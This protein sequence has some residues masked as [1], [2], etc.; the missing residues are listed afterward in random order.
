MGR[1]NIISFREGVREA[2][3][4]AKQRRVALAL[5]S[6]PAP[7]AWGEGIRPREATVEVKC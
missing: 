7:E 6:D 4:R 2:T 1:F 3:K 5:C